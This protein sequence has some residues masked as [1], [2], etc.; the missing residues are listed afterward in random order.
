[1]WTPCLLVPR[2][3]KIYSIMWTLTSLSHKIVGHR[4][5]IHQLD[6]ILTVVRIVLASG[7]PFLPLYSNGE[8]WR[9]RSAEQHEYALPHLLEIYRKPPK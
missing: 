4:W 5:L 3:Y 2:L 6:I 9:L 7:Y 1:M 8:L